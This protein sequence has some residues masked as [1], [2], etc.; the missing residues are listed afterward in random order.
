MFLYLYDTINHQIEETLNELARIYKSAD[1]Q[2]YYS[3]NFE[4]PKH[5]I[6]KRLWN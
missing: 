6:A 5:I 3:V 4:T 1:V 2:L